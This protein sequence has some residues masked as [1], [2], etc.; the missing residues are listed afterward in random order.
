MCGGHGGWGDRG[1]DESGGR[2]CKLV[3]QLREHTKHASFY[4]GYMFT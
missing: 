4:L 3:L 1:D 2:C